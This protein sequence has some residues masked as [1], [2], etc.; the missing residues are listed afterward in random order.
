MNNSSTLDSPTYR[1]KLSTWQWLLRSTGLEAWFRQAPAA[2]HAG[3]EERIFLLLT[4]ANTTRTTRSAHAA[5]LADAAR[6]CAA[7][8]KAS[9]GELL[10][11]QLGT[12]LLA[13]PTTSQ[14][15][16]PV[17]ALYFQLR[18]CVR[19]LASAP[20]LGLSGAAGLGWSAPGTARRYAKNSLRELAGILH[21]SQ[22]VGSDLLLAAALHQRLAPTVAEP[23]TLHVAFEVPGHRYPATLYRV[24]AAVGA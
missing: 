16:P 17:A 13:W 5:L 23:C 4:L 15:L 1:G 24:A 19:R 22:Q 7:S 21:E 2:A 14:A 11:Y 3:Q 10:T 12:L 9:G 8:I 18:D 20:A 6:E